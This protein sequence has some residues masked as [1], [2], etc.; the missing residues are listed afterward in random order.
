[1]RPPA[2]QTGRQKENGFNQC[3]NGTDDN[4]KKA[5]W[6]TNQPYQRKKDERQQGDRPTEDEQY[7]PDHECQ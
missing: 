3:E 7:A 1:M 6:K 4:A 2:E 5:Q